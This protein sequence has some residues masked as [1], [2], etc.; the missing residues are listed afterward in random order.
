MD[1][2]PDSPDRD[3]FEG[4]PDELRAMLE[5]LGGAMPGGAQ[6]LGDM[7]AGL[8]QM[9]S[10]ASGTTGPVDW[11]LARRIAI[12]IA[13]ESDRDPDEAEERAARE[14]FD[15]AEHWLDQ[16]TLPASPDGGRLDVTG[17]VAWVQAALEALAPLVEPVAAASTRA[18]GDLARQQMEGGAL[19]SLGLGDLGAMLGGFDPAAMLAPMGAM[20]S[21]MQAGQVVGQLSQQL[22]GQ[23]DLGIP[24]ADPARAFHIAVNA[25]EVFEGWDLDPTEVAI[26][27][28][29]HEGA[30]RRLFHAVSW[31]QPHVHRLVAQFADGVV[32]DPHRLEQMSRDLMTDVDPDDPE[33]LQRAM[34]RAGDFRIEPTPEQERILAR[35]QAVVGL[36]QAWARREVDRA[37]ASRLPNRSRIEEVLRRRRATRGEGDRLLAALLGL[38]LAPPDDAVGDAFVARV[39]E[40]GGPGALHKAL[41]HPE[42]LPDADELG[43]PDT[44]LARLAPD[45]DVPDDVASLFEGLGDAPV[46]PTAD[47]RVAQERR[48]R[49]GGSDDDDGASGGDESDGSGGPR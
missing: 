45:S 2:T 12:Q 30:H 7:L 20:M 5:Q 34:E 23:F 14:A 11:Q 49:E 46:E 9:F 43:A 19:E 36:V 13:D 39:E 18:L 40:V 25:T 31:L 47:E 1:D 24:T 6:G 17:R 26:V 41:A 42:N 8:Q 3:P 28:A 29:L 15:I 4:L 16:G 48:R 38:D 10:G 44:W 27:L 37:A 22:I 21:G 35:L 32:V 33:S